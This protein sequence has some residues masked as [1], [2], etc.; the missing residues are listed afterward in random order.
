MAGTRV[1]FVCQSCG[2][3]QPKWSGRCD[4]CGAWNTLVEETSEPLAKGAPVKRRSRRG[5]DLVSLEGTGQPMQRLVTG[6][7]ELD[8]AVGGGMVAGSA[9]LIG[10][11]PGIG[12]S[13]L[14]LQAA[15]RLA[16]AGKRVV[17]VSGEE[18]IEQIRMRADRIGLAKAPVELASGTSVDEILGTLDTGPPVDLLIIDSIQTVYLEA[19]DPAPGTVTQLRASAQALTRFAK[20]RGAALLLIGHVT[21]EGQIAGPRVLEHM[22]DTVL[23]FEGERGHQFRLLRAVKNRFGPANEIGVFEMRE[24]GLEPVA[25][26]SALF[27]AGRDADVSGAAVFAGMEGSRPV[28]VEIQALV[29]ASP[30]AT[31]RR[32][33]VGWDSG[34]LAMLLAVLEARCGLVMGNRDVYLNVAGGLR[35]TEPAADLAVAA[36]LVSSLADRAVPRMTVFFG[37]V[38]LGGEVRAVANSEARM[39]EAAKLGFE[40]VIAP[41]SRRGDSGEGLAIEELSRL[42]ELLAVMNFSLPEAGTP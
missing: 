6:I 9:I 8:R 17:Y 4:G 16:L 2:S 37:E 11:D 19:L 39:K 42:D 36:A 38:G 1:Q 14:T 13:T 27:L 29:A 21:K 18:S 33:V 30:L 10:G 12:K 20:R 7:G 28:L 23:Y 40:R 24:S 35:I 15:A 22:V 5:L 3:V 41:R 25:N 31:P 32:A 26:P 34:R